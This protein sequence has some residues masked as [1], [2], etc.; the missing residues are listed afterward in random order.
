M[1]HWDQRFLA[2]AEHISG[3]S[4]DPSTKVGAVIVDPMQ[5]VVS[6]GF[7]GF[8]RGIADDAR[9]DD[10]AVKY[11]ITVH[12]E[13]NAILFAQR[14]LAG[15]TLFNWPLP[16]CSRCAALIIQAGISRVV[17]PEPTERWLS[18]CSTGRDLLTEAGVVSS[19]VL[20]C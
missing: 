8:P 2:L 1:N 4:R 14:P 16:P 10:R 6:M 3:W 20:A 18:S 13:A 17:A 9:L 5:R 11:E 15:C 7:N 12:A 19:W